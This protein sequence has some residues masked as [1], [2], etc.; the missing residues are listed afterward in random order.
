MGKDRICSELF[1]SFD[2]PFAR[3]SDSRLMNDRDKIMWSPTLCRKKGAQDEKQNDFSD[4][5]CSF[6]LS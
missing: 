2:M 1:D 4:L 5:L 3:T 6:I